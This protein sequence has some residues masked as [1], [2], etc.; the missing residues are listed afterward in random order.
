M[1]TRHFTLHYTRQGNNAVPAR[2]ADRN[3]IPDYID[4]AAE[5]WEHVWDREIVQLGYPA[6]VGT[7]TQRFHVYYRDFAFYG[8]TYPENVQTLATS[9]VPLGT[10]SAYIEVEND[11]AGLPANDED[12]T[13]QE[14]IRTGALK[15]TE[16]HEFMHACQ[17]NINVYQSGWLF[18]S[19]ATWAE[20][21][22]YDQVNDWHWYVPFFFTTPD[23]PLFNRYVYGSAFFMN[24]LS[25]TYGVDATR[26]IWLAARTKTTPDAI[27]DAGLGGS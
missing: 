19:H 1:T 15:V 12:V 7:P 5:S 11:F 13:G 20:D 4:A 10:A 2:D 22:V 16:A 27:R 17:F 21:A 9:P 25:E 18:E 3:G 8:V 14:E 26:Q 24:Y 23:L 6:P